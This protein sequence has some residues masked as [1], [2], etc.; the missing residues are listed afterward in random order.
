MTSEDVQHLCTYR[1]IFQGG[2]CA[3][4]FAVLALGVALKCGAQCL[5]FYHHTVGTVEMHTYIHHIHPQKS[6]VFTAHSFSLPAPYYTYTP[7]AQTGLGNVV[8][9]SSSAVYRTG[10]SVQ[11]V[12]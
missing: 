11:V 1:Q 9:F 6:L 8:N 12:T 5:V 3:I 2:S 10:L 4:Q 7:N